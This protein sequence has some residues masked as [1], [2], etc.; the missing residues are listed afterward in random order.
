ME[1]NHNKI[2]SK[3]IKI[4]DKA[5]ETLTLQLNNKRIQKKFKKIY[6]LINKN[7]LIISF[8]VIFTYYNK[9][10]FTSIAMLISN[11]ILFYI[12]KEKFNNNNDESYTFKNFL[13]EVDME[14]EVNLLKLG[15]FF[16]E[17]FCHNPAVFEKSYRKSNLLDD[18][19]DNKPISVLEI[20][21]KFIN[22]IEN[23]NIFVLPSSLP[24]ICKPND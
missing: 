23:K 17:I 8:T 1:N 12:Y 5:N 21:T 9:L 19:E 13:R 16:I 3:Y 2:R 20:D 7:H 6:E 24:M 22:S 14:D 11:N 15:S 10:G 18:N 4:F